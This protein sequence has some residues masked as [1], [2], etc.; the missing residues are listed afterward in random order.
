MSRSE[1][2]VLSKVGE[3]SHCLHCT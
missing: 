1:E 3:N 2:D